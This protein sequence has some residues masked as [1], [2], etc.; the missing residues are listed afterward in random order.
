MDKNFYSTEP[1]FPTLLLSWYPHFQFCL[2]SGLHHQIYYL[3]CWC[4]VWHIEYLKLAW[5]A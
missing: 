4:S 3:P 1:A 2:V 5:V